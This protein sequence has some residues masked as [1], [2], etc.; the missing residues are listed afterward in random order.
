MIIRVF[1]NYSETYNSLRS[2]IIEVK[3]CR[4]FISNKTVFIKYLCTLD[5]SADLFTES[6]NL[7]KHN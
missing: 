5:M 1:K 7:L 3:Y 4:K 6:L 2:R